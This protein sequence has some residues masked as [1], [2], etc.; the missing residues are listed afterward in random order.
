[1]GALISNSSSGMVMCAVMFPTPRRPDAA[2]APTET[3]DSIHAGWTTAGNGARRRDHRTVRSRGPRLVVVPLE[4]RGQAARVAAA[5]VKSMRSIEIGDPSFVDDLPAD[6]HGVAA[7]DAGIWIIN[8]AAEL[9]G[10]IDPATYGRRSIPRK[11][12]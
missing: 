11:L 4:D 6:P 2:A 9:V 10:R 12:F 3:L 5:A 8:F 1:M 7:G